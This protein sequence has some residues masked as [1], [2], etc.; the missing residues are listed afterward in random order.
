MAI[1]FRAAGT[2]SNGNNATSLTPGLPSGTTSGDLLIVQ[3][4]S[5][6]G[7]DSRVPSVGSDWTSYQWNNGTSRHLLAWKFARTGESAPTITWTGT[8]ATNDTMVSRVHG[9]YT[10]S[11]G[12]RLVL[13]VVGDNSTN[14]SADNIGPIS[15][16]TVPTGGGLVVISAGKSNDFNGQGA[17]TNYTQAALT[18]STTGNDAGMT[19]MYRLAAPAGATG[20][21]TVQDDGSTA[22]NG[23]GLGKML[24][25]QEV[26]L[27]TL[28]VEVLQNTTVIA[29]R[30]AQSVGWSAGNITVTLTSGERGDISDASALRVRVT[31]KGAAGDVQVL[32]ISA[33]IDGTEVPGGSVPSW[34]YRDLC[35]LTSG[36]DL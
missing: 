12:K 10:D 26:D 34:Y 33:A 15:G 27:D 4:Q 5:F 29:T 22:S 9:F 32:E 23:V 11:S 19:L 30:T 28:D 25:F 20:N 31:K 24:C 8:G 2:A 1:V 6:G 7:T 36:D 17:L 21:L 14:A 35:G 16:I 13:A 18:E 3:A